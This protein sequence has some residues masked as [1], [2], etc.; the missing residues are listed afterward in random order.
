M[1]VAVRSCWR[2]VRVRLGHLLTAVGLNALRLGEWFLETAR[3][4][5]RISPFA[6]LMAD[7]T[8]A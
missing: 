4:K 2:C 5:T 8:A 7:G 1:A 6:R 3:A